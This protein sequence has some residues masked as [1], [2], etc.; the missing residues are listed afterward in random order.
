MR[1][2]QASGGLHGPLTRP[3]TNG[4]EKCVLDAILSSLA[5]RRKKSRDDSRLCRLDSPRHGGECS[6]RRGELTG[7]PSPLLGSLGCLAGSL[8][9]NAGPGTRQC[10]ALAVGPGSRAPAG[11]GSRGNR[12]KRPKGFV[13]GLGIRKS[14]GQFR[15][16]EHHISSPA[17]PVP[18]LAPNATGKVVLRSPLGCGAP[19]GRFLHTCVSHGSSPGGR[20]WRLG[21]LEGPGDC[22]AFRKPARPR[23]PLPPSHAPRY[24]WV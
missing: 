4:C 18:V 3:G 17:V 12:H 9:W 5:M 13:Y 6:A 22:L 14:V 7:P 10:W 19:R 1:L 16:D 23:G 20:R 15:V 11:F 21:A 2:D 24:K 8:P